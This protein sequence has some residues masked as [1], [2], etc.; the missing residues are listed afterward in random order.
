METIIKQTREVGTSAGVLL[1]RHWLN[2]EV[3]VTLYQPSIKEISAEAVSKLVW[4]GLNA[5][6]IGLYLYGS[7]ARGENEPKSDIDLLAI[8]ANTNRLVKEGNYEILL[9]S[10]KNLLKNLPTS[11]AYQSAIMEAKPIINKEFIEN[12][13]KNM[14][15]FNYKKALREI[16]RII[17]INKD[18]VETCR[19]QGMKIPDGI[20]Y[21]LVLRLRE[22]YLI[23]II[24]RNKSFS[25]KDFL[26]IVGR[27]AYSAYERIKNDER[28]IGIPTDSALNLLKISEKW[29]KELKG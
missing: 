7:Y 14:P 12:A 8:T 23:R 21:S 26:E 19:S 6:I 5:D 13:R 29:L 15:R 20:I 3:V 24:I 2:K 10:K 9:V 1:P 18:A 28:D 27:K 16:K 22:I 25:K 4:L 17:R 11:I